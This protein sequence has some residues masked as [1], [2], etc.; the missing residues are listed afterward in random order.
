MCV[1]SID[2]SP[3]TLGKDCQQNTDREGVKAKEGTH[4]LVTSAK[5]S[6][7]S[8]GTDIK[9]GKKNGPP[10]CECSRFGHLEDWGEYLVLDI[11]DMRDN[12]TQGGTWLCPETLVEVAQEERKARKK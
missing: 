11:E 7:S 2:F 3:D 1:G 5:D 6:G 9:E 4:S 12:S 10:H 8:G